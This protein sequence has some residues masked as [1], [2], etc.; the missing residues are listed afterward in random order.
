M[1]SRRPREVRYGLE[2]FF[3]KISI[4]SSAGPGRPRS[5]TATGSPDRFAVDPAPPHTR[6]AEPVILYIFAGPRSDSGESR[7]FAQRRGGGA[8][9][10][11]GNMGH[12]GEAVHISG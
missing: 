3:C 6:P 9:V 4:A 5:L 2:A 1:Y 12:Q 11:P 10:N 8:A 7:T